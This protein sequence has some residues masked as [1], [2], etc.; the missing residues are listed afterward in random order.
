MEHLV[1]V[2]SSIFSFN[3]MINEIKCFIVSIVSIVFVLIVIDII[4]GA[5][6][7]K[8]VD[9]MPNFSGQM[10]KDNY[11][12]HRLQTDIVILG[13]SRGSHHYVTS[14]LGDSINCYKNKRYSIY[15]AAIDGKFANS[16][17]CAAEMILSRYKPKLVIIDLQESQLITDYIPT[18]IKFSSPFYRKDSIVRRYLDNLSFEERLLMKSSLYRYNGKVFRIVSSFLRNKDFD[19]GYVPLFGS[20]IDTNSNEKLTPIENVTQFNTYSEKNLRNVLRKYKTVNVPLI[21]SCSPSFKPIDNNNKL[22]DLCDEYNVPFI[23]LY[24]LPYFNHHPELFKDETHLN[25]DGARVFTHLFF[26][27]IKPYLREIE[28]QDCYED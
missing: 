12:L 24:N 4:W 7:D 27:Q 23:E 17:F 18:D 10:A 2:N 5:F 11:R 25:A 28:N 1:A 3:L 9:Q 20:S 19:D 6:A 8:V 22:R 26:T 14:L 21:I 15:N 16:N 13:S